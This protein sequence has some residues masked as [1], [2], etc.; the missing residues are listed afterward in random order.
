MWESAPWRA[1]TPVFLTPYWLK[2]VSVWPNSLGS[3]TWCGTS[4]THTR[5]NDVAVGQHDNRRITWQLGRVHTSRVESNP[6]QSD[7][8]RRGSDWLTM[9]DAA[10][11]THQQSRVES[12]PV[13]RALPSHESWCRMLHF[14]QTL[15]MG[16]DGCYREEEMMWRSLFS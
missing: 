11:G 16:R 10:V 13:T 2:R 8:Q 12:S 1:R 6:V 14:R 7:S 9:A 4:Y 15:V 3:R 5:H